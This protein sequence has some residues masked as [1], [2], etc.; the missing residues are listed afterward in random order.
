MRA[1]RGR[2]FFKTVDLPI[3]GF[4]TLAAL[5]LFNIICYKLQIRNQV[6]NMYIIGWSYSQYLRFGLRD[7]QLI[8]KTRI[9][10]IHK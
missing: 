3:E 7:N 6:L 1:K 4:N 10:F 9:S 2:I 8:M 5:H